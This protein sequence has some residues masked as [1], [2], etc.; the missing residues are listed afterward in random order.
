MLLGLAWRAF[1][2]NI[3]FSE[4][5]TGGVKISIGAQLQETQIKQDLTTY[6]QTQGYQNTNISIQVIENTT[7]LSIKTDVENDEKVNILSKDIQQFLLDK[8][9][10]T[11]SSMILEQSIT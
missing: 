9:Y 8:K 7:Q 3:R 11:S 5:F 2:S 1:F 6:L 4:E 10:I